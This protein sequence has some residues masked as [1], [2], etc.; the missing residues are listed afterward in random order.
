MLQYLLS[1]NIQL[2]MNVHH[3]LT[4]MLEHFSILQIFDTA[5]KL[6]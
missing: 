3:L 6:L 2:K 5:F 1:V 4:E